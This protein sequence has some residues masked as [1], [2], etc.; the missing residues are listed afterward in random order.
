MRQDIRPMG[1]QQHR[2]RSGFEYTAHFE[3]DQCK[4]AGCIIIVNK[5]ANFDVT[6]FFLND[7]DVDS[8]GVPVWGLNQFEG[9][10]LDPGRAM[11]TVRPLKMN[12]ETLVRF[13]LRNRTT[14]EESEGIQ[15]FNM[16]AMSKKGGFATLSV[17]GDEA[18]VIL[19]DGSTP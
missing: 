16:C 14:K 5:S 2:Y 8:R 19:E 1:F 13:V 11:W 3:A 9:F 12:C 4:Q 15:T 6:Q 17:E 7:G 18:R 10:H